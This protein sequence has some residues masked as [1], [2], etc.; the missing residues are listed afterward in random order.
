MAKPLDST[1]EEAARRWTRF[2]LLG[3]FESAWRESELIESTGYQDPH[4][5]WTG[6]PWAGKRVMLRCLHGLGDTIQFIRYAPLLKQT[7]H[8]LTVQCHPE[9]VSLLRQVPA[10]DQAVTWGEGEDGWDLQLEVTEL[11]RA[12]RTTVS[13]IPSAVPY[14]FVS[15]QQRRWAAN[16]LGDRR[17][18]RAG[19]VWQASTFNP[20]RSI[21]PA[22]LLPLLSTARC[23][24]CILQK[25]ARTV[26]PAHD[27]QQHANDVAGTAA[28]MTQ[29]DLMITV[30]TM[31]AHL[32]GSLGIPVWILLPREA[33][34][35][36]MM[37]RPD[38]PWYPSATLFRQQ[39][40]DD[41]EP[42]IHQVAEK[43]RALTA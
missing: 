31:T 28:L 41:W 22:H 4:K 40:E 30:D 36:W 42:V 38:S 5:F 43:L 35:R 34:W 10:V 23:D 37:D 16:L 7:C 12:F 13:T 33:D 20:K 2:M 15:E 26:L 17:H 27:L 39:T 3:D 6:D 9:L 8:T 21:P 1:R 19:L 24:F 29:L 25:G 18:F 11:P 32:A 14:I